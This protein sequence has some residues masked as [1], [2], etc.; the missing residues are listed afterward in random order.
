MTKAAVAALTAVFLSTTA[1]AV[2]AQSVEQIDHRVLAT[3]KT[4][5]MEKE[6]NEA[7]KAGYRFD[8]VMG[9]ETAAGGKEVVAVM[10]RPA[11]SH[12]QFEYRLLATNRTSSMEKELRSASEL[13]FDYR[14][15]T[16]FE[17][18][19][20]GREVVCILERNLDQGG[21]SRYE[22][23]LL[24]TARTSTM[25]KELEGAGADG[26]EVVGMTVGKTA[27]GGDEI[28]A[29]ARRKTH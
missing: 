16:V 11:G 9:G 27:V 29:I 19:F 7:A 20:G 15:Q 8:A 25:Q 22:Y 1:A 12:D 23:R 17:S 26:F 4:S 14:A 28:V 24:A 5:T 18:V 10:S 6:M 21:G 13:G 2:R 3:T